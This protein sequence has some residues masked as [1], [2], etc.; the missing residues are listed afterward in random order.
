LTSKKIVGIT[1]G[2][3]SGKTFVCR[4]LKAMGYPVFFSDKEAKEILTSSPLVKKQIT[5]LFG[6]NSYLKNGDLNR[7]YLSSQIFNDKNKLEQMNQIVHPAVRESFKIW[8]QKQASNIVFNEAA[9]LFETGA[10]K[11]YDKT[12][13]I[14]ASKETKIKRIQKRDNI[15]IENIKSRMNSQWT[16]EKK[17]PLADFIITND[18]NKM[19]IP[20]LIKVINQLN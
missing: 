2:I 13:L 12:I 3:G 7:Q 18:E 19:L 5:N 16:D 17:K 15:S 9:I 11:I 8:T 1:G 20:Q 4:V 6:Q 10:F 14:T